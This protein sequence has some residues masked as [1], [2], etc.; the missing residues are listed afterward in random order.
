MRFSN[1]AKNVR[2]LRVTNTMAISSQWFDLLFPSRNNCPCAIGLLCLSD[3][4]AFTLI[5]ADDLI[6]H[7]IRDPRHGSSFWRYWRGLSWCCWRFC[8]RC[9]R[10]F[11]RR[12]CSRCHCEGSVNAVTNVQSLHACPGIFHDRESE[13]SRI[14]SRHLSSWPF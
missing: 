4:R 7:R 10:S 9:L 2:T 13:L 6:Y 5:I 8:W 12:S 14:L 3:C 1:R 11:F